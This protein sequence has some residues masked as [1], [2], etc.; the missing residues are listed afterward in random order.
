M[1]AEILRDNGLGVED[2]IY[3]GLPHG[4]WTT[5]PEL[6]VSKAWGSNG[7][8]KAHKARKCNE[9]SCDDTY[10]DI[11]VSYILLFAS[12]ILEVEKL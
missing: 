8:S 5:Y 9:Q 4:F 2:R 12:L 3:P 10:D 6:P 11:H 7:H 1:F